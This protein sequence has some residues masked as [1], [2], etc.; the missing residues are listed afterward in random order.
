MNGILLIL[1]LL[2]FGAAMSSSVGGFVILRLSRAAPADMAVLG[3]VPPVL[4]RVGQTGLGLLWLTGI[5]MVW[6][7][8]GG[9][10]NL[11][12][13]FWLKFICVLIVTVG[14]V[15]VSLTIKAIQSGDRAKV[16]RLPLYGAV[17]GAFLLL[18][19]I[20]AVYAFN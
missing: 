14:V 20:F 15:M 12:G 16:V 7:K 13:L 2:G 8:F 4:I 3:K 17:N 1:H 10:E 6:T 11:P 19:V 18:V 5:I 9:P